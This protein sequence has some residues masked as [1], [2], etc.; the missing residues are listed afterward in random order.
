MKR[1][2]TLL[3]IIISNLVNAQDIYYSNSQQ[4]LIVLNPSFAGSNGGARN[5]T[6][7]R[8]VKGYFSANS[9]CDVYYRKINA[10]F[11]VTY[12]HEDFEGG[13]YKNDVFHITYAQYFY[14]SDK[15]TKFIPSVQLG[16]FV[17]N[18]DKTKLSFEDMYNSYG[19]RA[20]CFVWDYTEPASQKINFDASAGLLLQ[21]KNFIFGS[22]VYHVT[23]PDEG[24]WGVQKLPILI[25]IHSSYNWIVKDNFLINLSGRFFQQ[26]KFQS[27]QFMSK[28]LLFKHY[29]IGVGY[30][31]YNGTMYNIGYRH[32]LF[33]ISVSGTYN[34]ETK[35][36][37]SEIGASYTLRNKDQR[38]QLTCMENW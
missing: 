9:S 25:N 31:S 14:S 12:N 36:S 32:K 28:A 35:N 38:K 15:Q 16:G 10:G 3:T 33:N 30:Q 13:L 22:S 34:F 5:Q 23:Q 6:N 4:S 2:I 1:T 7:F 17:R 19:G 26:N 11:A 29:M 8:S 24:M 20:R 27:L 21:H 37:I 18:L